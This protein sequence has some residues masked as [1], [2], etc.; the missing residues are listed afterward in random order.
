M[1]VVYHVASMGD[2]WYWRH[3]VADQFQLLSRVGLTSVRLTHVGPDLADVL[4]MAKAN[5]ITA[6]VWRD[7]NARARYNL[8]RRC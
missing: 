3:V 4:A 5:G 1:I 6:T 8:S 7:P 2:P